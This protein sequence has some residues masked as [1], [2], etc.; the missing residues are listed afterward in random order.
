MRRFWE[1]RDPFPQ[2]PQN[3]L[4]DRWEQRIAIARARF[5]GITDDRA[6]M[7]LAEV[8][9]RE[10]GVPARISNVTRG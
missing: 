2:T 6:R 3:E 10:F 9:H 8:C 5:G 7:L 4:K 1:V